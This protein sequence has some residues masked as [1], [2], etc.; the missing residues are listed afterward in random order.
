MYLQHWGLRVEPFDQRMG[1]DWF[2]PTLFHQEALAR[3]HFL[4]ENRRPL[5]FMAGPAGCGKTTVLE[6]FAQRMR[7]AGAA[8]AT[9]GLRSLMEEEVLT[10]AAAGLG[11]LVDAKADARSLWRTLAG[12]LTALRIERQTTLILLDD[13]EGGFAFGRRVVERLLAANGGPPRHTVVLS[14]VETDLRAFGRD[15]LERA[16]LRIDVPPLAPPE[17][18]DYVLQRL[19]LAGASRAIFEFAGLEEIARLSGGVPRRINQLAQLCL[20]AGAASGAETIEAALVVDVYEEMQPFAR[21]LSSRQ[22][23]AVPSG[24]SDSEAKAD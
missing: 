9:I 8:V 10:A 23:A 11:E 7:A 13:A 21:S 17:T 6:T 19:T 1:A 20:V 15:L 4:A 5:G 3:L 2:V 16:D 14:G 22:T 18:A 12:R 24:W